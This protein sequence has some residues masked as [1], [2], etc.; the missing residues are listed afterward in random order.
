MS[1]VKEI[2]I[3][4]EEVNEL[5]TAVPKWIVRWGV[6]IIFL[7]MVLALSLSFFIKYPDTLSAKT[8]ITTANPP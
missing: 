5:L 8:I 6:T 2:E 7:V 1:E 3:K 4:T